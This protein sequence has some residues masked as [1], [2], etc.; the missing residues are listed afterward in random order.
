MIKT[1]TA[2]LFVIFLV[3]AFLM[4]FIGPET[5]FS[6]MEN[7]VMQQKPSL[8]LDAILSGRFM[9]ESVS[10]I[11]DQYWQRSWWVRVKN[12][13]ERLL[14]KRDIANTYLG[15]ADLYTEK[16]SPINEDVFNRNLTA[17]QSFCKRSSLMG[18]QNW[19]LLVPSSYSIYPQRLP[20]FAPVT[21]EGE[22]SR[23]ITALD[24]DMVVVDSFLSLV[25]SQRSDLYFRTDHHWTSDGALLAAE[26][27]LAAMGDIPVGEASF[28][29][30]FITGFLGS[31]YSRAPLFGVS[32]EEVT[33]YSPRDLVVS[34]RYGEKGETSDSLLVWENAGVKDKYTLF[35]GSLQ[36]E[37]SIITSAESPRHLLILKDSFAHPLVP[38]LVPFFS[39]I[40]LL[41]LRYFRG[42]VGAYLNEHKITDVLF[43][44]NLS[45]FASDTFFA[46]AL[47][48]PD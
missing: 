24:S 13:S 1:Q 46:F 19:F 32:A 10:Y 43:C 38:H 27:V 9:S 14:G 42:S 18:L 7:R 22:L 16:R 6:E 33:Y 11:Q 12:G 36:P 4:V 39:E 48:E 47:N 30:G 31:L 17:L 37:V 21:D 45:W 34:M 28:E 23:V 8:T 25:S 5:A 29:R 40:R 15:E 3:L 35:L 44:Y 41:D 2:L 26:A 20:S